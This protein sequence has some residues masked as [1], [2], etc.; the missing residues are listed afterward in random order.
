MSQGHG[1]VPTLWLSVEPEAIYTF[2]YPT[3]SYFLTMKCPFL[4]R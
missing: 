1:R 3:N 2:I 4:H